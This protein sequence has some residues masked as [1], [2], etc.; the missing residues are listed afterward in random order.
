MNGGKS[1]KLGGV[2][3]QE[4][5]PDIIINEIDQQMIKEAIDIIV[6]E[7]NN[8]QSQQNQ[9]LDVIAEEEQEDYIGGGNTNSD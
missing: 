9:D 8:P 4:N 7:Q 2:N 5:L 6:D 1:R 3:E